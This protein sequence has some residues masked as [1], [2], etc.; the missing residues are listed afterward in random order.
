MKKFLAFLF[1]FFTFT[2]AV[3]QAP[4]SINYQGVARNASGVA[5]AGQQISVRISIHSVTPDGA[6]EYS[7]TRSVTTNQFGLF[8]IQIGSAGAANVQGNF[9]GINWSSTNKFLQTEISINNQPFTSLGTTQM[10]SVPFAISSQQTRQLVFPFDT[11]VNSHSSP[12]LKI[13]NTSTSL[14]PAITGESINGIAVTGS[15]ETKSGVAGSAFTTQ[16][17]GVTGTNPAM[18]GYGVHGYTS[19]TNTTG[20][21]VFGQALHGSGVKG[22]TA[23]GNGVF[24][25][26]TA[27][28]TGVRAM[29]TDLGFGVYSSAGNGTAVFGI[30]TGNTGTAGKFFQTNG[31][32]MAL[33]VVGNM[34]ISGGNTNPGVGKVLTSDAAGNARWQNLP[35]LP[36]APPKVAFKVS[37]VYPGGLNNYSEIN[38][39]KVYFN[40]VDYDYGNTISVGGT[41]ANSVF[42]APHSGVYHFDASVGIRSDGVVGWAELV[43]VNSAG[44]ISSLKVSAYAETL[45]DNPDNI[46]QRQNYS[47]STDAKLSAGDKV[48]VRF[49]WFNG[50]FN[51]PEL[52]G[53]SASQGGASYVNVTQFSGHMV[54]AD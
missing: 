47:V 30:A 14:S 11:S 45:M 17:G 34:K 3:A 44:Q 1:L 28:G 46:G 49:R 54:F 13:K 36:A 23:F 12:V 10:M 43:R 8:T 20:A 7:E 2:A 52:T 24:A 15:S 27:E 42:T 35:A 51:D 4:Q 6:V 19:A 39:F 50:E 21:G 29:A 37:G 5:Y 9:P 22:E 33:E 32:G 41:A 38:W 31:G 48:Y 26:A 18:G 40:N 53:V 25:V 16:V